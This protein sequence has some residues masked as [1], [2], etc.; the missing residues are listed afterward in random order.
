MLVWKNGKTKYKT[1]LH[2]V[3]SPLR[4]EAFLW[5]IFLGWLQV[6]D[7]LAK[8]L[9]QVSIEWTA[10]RIRQMDKKLKSNKAP[11]KCMKVQG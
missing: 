1:N 5:E 9:H 7:Y 2:Y 6:P 10:A 4:H 11:P 3:A 8:C